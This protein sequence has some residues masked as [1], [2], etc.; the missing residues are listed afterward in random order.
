LR[1]ILAAGAGV[2]SRRCGAVLVVA[3]AV[4]LPAQVLSRAP[5]WGFSLVWA[6]ILLMANVALVAILLADLQHRPLKSITLRAITGASLRLLAAYL[7]AAFFLSLLALTIAI[8]IKLGPPSLGSSIGPASADL[9]G[10][11]MSFLL[12]PFSLL[13]PVCLR[14]HGGPWW[15]LKRAWS[16]SRPRRGQIWLLLGGLWIA[17]LAYLQLRHVPGLAPLAALIA[18]S[19]LYAVLQTILIS[20][21]YVRLVGEEPPPPAVATARSPARAAQGTFR[22]SRNRRTK[23]RPRR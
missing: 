15:S 10:A 17:Q 11:A 7:I 2:V 20:V 6:W 16:L 9:L 22:P 12:V 1:E 13:T 21:F 14:E 5:V 4:L 3:V 18:C 8:G 19:V 23:Q